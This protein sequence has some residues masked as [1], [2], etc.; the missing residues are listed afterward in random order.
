MPAHLWEIT[1]YGAYLYL[2]TRWEGEST[3]TTFRADLVPG[4]A[5]FTIPGM[6]KEEDFKAT[7]I[8]KQHFV[9]PDWCTGTK[10]GWD[11]ESPTYDVIFSR[12]GIGEEASPDHGSQQPRK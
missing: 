1:Q 8:D 6:G 2:K 4:E 5:A 3:F 7:L 9:I 10:G 11:G 12:P